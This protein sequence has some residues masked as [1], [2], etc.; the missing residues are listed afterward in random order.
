MTGGGSA[1]RWRLDLGALRAA[2]N[3]QSLPGISDL[4]GSGGSLF[5]QEVDPRVNGWNVNEG[6]RKGRRL[7]SGEKVRRIPSRLRVLSRRACSTPNR[8][9]GEMT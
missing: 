7:R 6:P 8:R 9:S 2:M 4:G 3:P 1:A 5:Y